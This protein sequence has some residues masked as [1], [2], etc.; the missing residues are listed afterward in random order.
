MESF[1]SLSSDSL[2]DST[3]HGSY[4][5]YASYARSIPESSYVIKLRQFSMCI[6]VV[7]NYGT[8]Q[9]QTL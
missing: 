9:V 6:A 5:T 2:I 3:Q 4:V 1:G 7:N 8:H